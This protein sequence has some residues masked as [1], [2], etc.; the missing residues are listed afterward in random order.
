MHF[1]LNLSFRRPAVS[2]PSGLLK[3]F[4]FIAIASHSLGSTHTHIL[5]LFLTLLQSEALSV[6]L[7]GGTNEEGTYLSL[8]IY[9]LSRLIAQFE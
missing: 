4:V 9:L 1:G 7:K 3:V 8:P 5:S 2:G 6:F